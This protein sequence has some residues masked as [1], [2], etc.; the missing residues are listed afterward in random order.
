LRIRDQ[1]LI[2]LVRRGRRI[3]RR[4][5]S[6]DLLDVITNALSLGEKLPSLLDRLLELL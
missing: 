5:G 6:V 1:V 3:R 4:E 2:R